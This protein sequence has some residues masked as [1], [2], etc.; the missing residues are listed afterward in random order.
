M[1]DN[2]SSILFKIW[3]FNRK[4]RKVFFQPQRTQRFFAE[5]AEIFLE[6]LGKSIYHTFAIS[7]SVKLFL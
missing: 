3:F 2:Q 4:E 1:A 7:K 6:L 5:D